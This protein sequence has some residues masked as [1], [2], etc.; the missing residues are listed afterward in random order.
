MR[1]LNLHRVDLNLLPG[2][3]ALLD[4]RHVSRAAERVGISQPSMSRTLHRLRRLFDD[5]LL[6]RGDEGYALTPRAER[7]RAQISTFLP[8]LDELFGMDAFDPALAARD[9]RIMLTDYTV[10][11]FGTALARAIRA[12]SPESTVSFEVLDG[13]A[14]DKLEGGTIDLLAL[15]RTP[16]PRYR[17]EKLFS[18]RFV[19]VVA[20]DHP[21]AKR[22]SM[23]LA[24]YLRWPHLA[25]DVEDGM[26]PGVDPVLH[27]LGVSRRIQLTTPFHVTAPAALPGSDLV[28]TFPS[29]LLS[30]VPGDGATRV[31]PAP[32]E[33]PPFG[34]YAVW[35]PRMD[36]D[37]WHRWLR[38]TLQAV[39]AS[40]A[41][42]APPAEG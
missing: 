15:G 1:P 4:E 3:V 36:A 5:E 35:H 7:I 18:D 19:S 24:Q 33:I 26:Q 29:R 8:S 12:E 42:G 38:R 2:L 13:R 28:L 27:S 14:L 34:I 37:P 11:A 22:R 10:S 16:P 40:P 6:V 20:A 9:I 23:G 17:A 31:I 39:T 21:L 32:P 30:W 41:S 25:I